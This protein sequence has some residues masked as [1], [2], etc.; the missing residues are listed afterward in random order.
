MIDDPRGG[1]G[2]LRGQ[3]DR[4]QDRKAWERIGLPPHEFYKAS[5]DAEQRLHAL[6]GM[7]WPCPEHAACAPIIE[8]MNR[9]FGFGEEFSTKATTEISRLRFFDADV[10][11]SRV[12]WCVTRHLA[13]AHIVET[14]VARGVTSRLLLEAIKRNGSG[15]LWSIDLPHPDT[16]QTSQIGS[17]VPDSLRGPWKLLLGPSRRCLPE[18]FKTLGKIDIFVHDSLHTSRNVRFELDYVWDRIRPGG[19]ILV[20]DV[21]ENVA[22]QSFVQAAQADAWVVGR[23][24]LGVG[25]WG[26][27][28]KQVRT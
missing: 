5:P 4:R 16:C 28:A 20:D 8:Q 22:F 9:E 2:R 12:A 10:T 26:A 18:L 24:S 17:A 15:A 19:V 21:N 13:P 7:P 1:L 14:G 6:L 27:I 3:W 25:L 11:I 23:R